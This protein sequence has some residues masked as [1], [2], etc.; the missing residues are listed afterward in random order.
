MCQPLFLPQMGK[1]R[2]DSGTGKTSI[3]YPPEP[4]HFWSNPSSFSHP[5]SGKTKTE[6]SEQTEVDL[7]SPIWR[8]P[9]QLGWH[10]AQTFSSDHAWTAM[11]RRIHYMSSRRIHYMSSIICLFH[12]TQEEIYGSVPLVSSTGGVPTIQI[13]I[14]NL[15]MLLILHV[16]KNLIIAA[17]YAQ[18]RPI[19][20]EPMMG[21]IFSLSLLMHNLCII[22]IFSSLLIY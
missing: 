2:M 12:G 20:Q 5:E 8:L 19:G 21:C 10:Q 1:R 15:T 9:L 6:A 16:H 18:T 11:D 22:E 13:L 4:T 3:C 14:Q 17:N 7:L